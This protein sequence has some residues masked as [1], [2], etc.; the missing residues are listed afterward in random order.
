MKLWLYFKS[1]DPNQRTY[2]VGLL[3][4]FVG[5]C[6]SY[7]VPAALVVV[8]SAIAAESV[9]TSYLAAWINRTQ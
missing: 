4:L 9:V 3:M 5:L 7:S 8:G 2:V 1:S 6:F